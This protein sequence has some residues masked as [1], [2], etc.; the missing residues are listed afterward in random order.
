MNCKLLVAMVTTT[1]IESSSLPFGG[2]SGGMFGGT[3]LFGEPIK[4]T[5]FPPP[6]PNTVIGLEYIIIGA[7]N[8]E[9]Y[10]DGNSTELTNAIVK[11][12]SKNGQYV[13]KLDYLVVVDT[14]IDGTLRQYPLTLGC[15]RRSFRSIEECIMSICKDE[16]V[17]KAHKLELQKKRQ[18]LEEEEQQLEKLFEGVSKPTE[19]PKNN[20]Q[21]FDGVCIC[22]GVPHSVGLF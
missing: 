8:N 11:K 10:Y 1:R 4:S 14:A 2:G 22:N 5:V 13:Y 21:H 12:L 16:S 3:N 20:C 15:T 17:Y 7:L 9:G 18:K 6:S 19:P